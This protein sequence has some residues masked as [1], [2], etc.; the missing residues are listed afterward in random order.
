[1]YVQLKGEHTGIEVVVDDQTRVIEL[2]LVS[3]DA[4]L[5]RKVRLN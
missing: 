4:R 2:C 1:M 5:V 3:L